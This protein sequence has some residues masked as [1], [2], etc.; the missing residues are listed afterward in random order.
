MI[1]RAV[2]SGVA[3]M[4]DIGTDIQTSRFAIRT[5]Q[6]SLHV[7]A[8]AGIHPHEALK[9]SESDWLL[10]ESLLTESKVVALG[11]IGLDYF[12]DFSPPE[13]Q[14]IVFKKQLEIALPR[15]LPVII[16]VRE[17]MK[18][19]LDVIDSVSRSSWRG[20]FH[21]YGGSLEDVPEVLERGFHVGFTGV[22]TFKNFAGQK[23]VRSVP[24]D[25]LLIETDA[26]YMTPVP[27]RGK[28]NEPVYVPHVAE[29]IAGIQGI[30]LEEI[31]ERTTHNA[32]ELFGITAR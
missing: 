21:C 32:R 24:L 11:E 23:I 2:E 30:P 17:S 1:A 28:R 18:D 19:A 4:I 26:P 15:Q 20:V 6:S 10:L 25:R 27:Y 13:V 14:K 29:A 8:A 12:Y 31:A 3:T 7:F 22:V 16:H 5:A 9:V